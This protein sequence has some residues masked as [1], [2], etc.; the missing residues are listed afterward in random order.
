MWSGLEDVSGDD[1]AESGDRSGSIGESRSGRRK[2]GNFKNRKVE[3]S[4]INFAD[5]SNPW[6]FFSIFLNDED[7]VHQWCRD[8][9]LLAHSLPCKSC[10]GQATLRSR[11]GFV[12]NE[13]FRCNKN[14]S[15]QRQ[16]R[17]FSFFEAAKIPTN[18]IM[19]FI[20]S[21]LDGCTLR[22]C[23]TFAG[24]SYG[25]SAVD[26]AGHI[27]ELFKDDFRRNR[28]NHKLSGEIE[29][30]ESLFGRRVKYHRGNP[31]V[32]VKVWVFGMV[33]RTSNTIILY[34]VNDRSE[35]TLIPLIERHVQPGSSIY[36]DGW[37]AYCDLNN[38]G[39][40]HF[41]VLHKYAFK[42]VYV[43][44]QTKEE[45]TVHT[46]RIEGAWKHAKSHF[47]KMSGTLS[48]QFEGH[49]AEIMWRSSAKTN[50]YEAFFGL[51]KTV[52][53]LTGPPV[54]AFSRNEP[55]FD[56]WDGAPQNSSQKE[57]VIPVTTDV[58][59]ET[60]STG[61]SLSA[62]PRIPAL[63]ELA[64]TVID[65][66][67]D[68]NFYLIGISSEDSDIPPNRPISQ[69]SRPTS[70]ATDQLLHEMFSATTSESG[71]DNDKDKTLVEDPL[72]ISRPK[73]STR[74]RRGTPTISEP[75]SQPDPPPAVRA[76]TAAVQQ[77]HRGKPKQS[78]TKKKASSSV[79]EQQTS[80][81]KS[82]KTLKTKEH[83]CHPAGFAEK[84]TDRPRRR[85]RSKPANNPYASKGA[86]VWEWSSDD[87]D[88]K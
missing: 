20:K 74:L 8:H 19:L 51:M 68:A 28:M 12:A 58:E 11:K 4:C 78:S 43:N 2:P 86:F 66:S 65:E 69:S 35:A 18:D 27:R 72:P 23:A 56:S 48:S 76:K 16:T 38:K 45:V 57:M 42:K 21:Y 83:V 85:R 6:N 32:G 70:S 52:Y 59:S 64:T 30:D 53:T 60:E 29:I 37:S 62:T 15:H 73:R 40:R 49:M 50:I 36:S 22:Q 54:F 3:R 5:F 41:T 26:W 1:G 17:E 33:E 34:P 67:Q 13:A 46:N 61:P 79:G 71:S 82:S 87:D 55:L 7:V 14:F 25:S 84:Q 39:Y 44:E 10:D 88:F 47:R 81:E 75:D 24:I 63:L 77:K 80:K 31:N 9:G